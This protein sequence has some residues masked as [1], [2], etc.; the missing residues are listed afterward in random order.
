MKEYSREAWGI[1]RNAY[2]RLVDAVEQG[3][4]PDFTVEGR[5][6]ELRNG[7]ITADELIDSFDSSSR[8]IS[9]STKSRTHINQNEFER[10]VSEILDKTADVVSYKFFRMAVEVQLFSRSGKTKWNT[11][12]DFDDN[13][14]I[15]GR[16]TY[17]ERYSG[18]SQPIAIGKNISRRI[19]NVL[20]D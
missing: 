2:N 15:T 13:G 3:I 19:E 10:I 18:A 5:I 8:F 20:Y 11:F 9:Q 7:L 4:L 14:I 17:T 6:Y 1:S 16:F 12:L